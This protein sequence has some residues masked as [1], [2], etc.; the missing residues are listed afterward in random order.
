[1][2]NEGNAALIESN[3]DS[4]ALPQTSAPTAH[5]RRSPR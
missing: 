2:I 4:D 1:M 3:L 5:D